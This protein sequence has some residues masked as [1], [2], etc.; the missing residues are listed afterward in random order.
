MRLSANAG[1]LHQMRAAENAGCLWLSERCCANGARRAECSASLQSEMRL[2]ANAGW[3]VAG[4]SCSANVARRAECSAFRQSEMQLRAD[5]GLLHESNRQRM[6]A[7]AVP[8]KAK[9]RAKIM[10]RVVRP[11]IAFIPRQ[12][13]VAEGGCTTWGHRTAASAKCSCVRM[14]AAAMQ[15]TGCGCRL[16]PCLC[17]RKQCCA[18]GALQGGVQR[19]Q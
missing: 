14:Q 19:L 15:A 7:V 16:L 3:C 2:G 10:H 13:H 11:P 5:A 8:R 17:K 12:R 18:N 9:L 1:L 4:V 6:R